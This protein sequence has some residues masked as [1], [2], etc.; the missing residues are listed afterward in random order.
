MPFYNAQKTIE[1]A[2]RSILDQTYLNWELLLLDDGSTDNSR[3]L[4]S[5]LA[6]PRIIVWSDGA[7]QGL[8][9]RLNECVER[10]R[11]AYIARMDSDDVSFPERLRKQVEFLESHPNI[12]LVGSSVLVFGGD[13]S[14]LGKRIVPETH[15]QITVEPASGF[16]MA[17]PTWMA[18]AVWFKTNR[19]DPRALRYEDFELL[20]RTY[21]TSK[22]ANLPELLYA[23]REP[24]GGFQKRLKTRMGRLGYFYQRRA[25]E[26]RAL[27][28]NAARHEV[29]K[30]IA[31][32]MIVLTS[33]RYAALKS[34]MDALTP[35]ENAQW[36]M[37]RKATDQSREM[38]TVNR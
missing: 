18:R 33:K 22:F 24:S 12:D 4:V 5:N 34:R 26:G 30:V 21:Q 1:A 10:A 7:Q 2:V 36:E 31:D 23:Y 13:G 32:A 6:D 16:S 19:Y 28:W 14:A 17:H 38:E 27:F 9:P 35:A 15:Q 20:Y 8:A 29:W 11:G 3:A 37:V 25:S